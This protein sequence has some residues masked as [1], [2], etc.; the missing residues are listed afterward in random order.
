MANDRNG[1]L[2]VYFGLSQHFGSNK[3]LDNYFKNYEISFASNIAKKGSHLKAQTGYELGINF[4]SDG[5]NV[6]LMTARSYAQSKFEIVSGD[7][8]KTEMINF[9]VGSEFMLMFHSAKKKL[10]IGFGVGMCFF[11]QIIKS[12]RIIKADNPPPADDYLSGRYSG[13]GINFSIY[14]QI[15][16]NITDNLVLY[17]KPQYMLSAGGFS[18]LET[19]DKPYPNYFPQDPGTWQRKLSSYSGDFVR[20]ELKGIRFCTGIS[21][22]L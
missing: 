13:I 11:K 18:D 22:I 8:R 9:S 17:L 20:A 6:S 4:F 3:G 12:E 14:P 1:G 2:Q 16:Y 15:E 21:I 5:L 10:N 19:K 7:I